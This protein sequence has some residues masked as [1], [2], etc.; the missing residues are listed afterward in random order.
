MQNK[1]YCIK[2]N[3]RE[4]LVIINVISNALKPTTNLKYI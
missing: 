3:S 1:E 4:E 2:D